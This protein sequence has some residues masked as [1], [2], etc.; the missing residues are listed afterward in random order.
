MEE[1]ADVGELLASWVRSYRR[2]APLTREAEEEIPTFMMLRRMMV[3]AWIASHSDTELAQTEGAG[4]TLGTCR[5]AT[6][7]LDR[8]A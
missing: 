8:F 6:R 3:M 2:L 5:L 7:F 4:Y 1:R